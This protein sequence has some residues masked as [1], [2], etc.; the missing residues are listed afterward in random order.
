MSPMSTAEQRG[1]VPQ[2]QGQR[3]GHL[4]RHM[5]MHTGRRQFLA[6]AL[7]EGA[8]VSHAPALSDSLARAP[9]PNRSRGRGGRNCLQ[10]HRRPARARAHRERHQAMIGSGH[11]QRATNWLTIGIGEVGSCSRQRRS[12]AA[13]CPTSSLHTGV[14]MAVAVWVAESVHQRA[15]DLRLRQD[16][17]HGPRV[18]RSNR[19]PPQGRRGALV[20]GVE[21]GS[22]RG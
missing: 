14:A 16:K 4:A 12:A 19:G 9:C 18:R 6:T 21:R 5:P 3:L 13:G 1:I 7:A 17:R 20:V 11:R 10:Y 22:R 8:C 15:V 2:D